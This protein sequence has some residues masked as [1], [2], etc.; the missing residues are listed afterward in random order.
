M[1]NSITAGFFDAEGR[2]AWHNQGWRLFIGQKESTPLEFLRDYYG[3]GSI[4][5]TS[6]GYSHWNVW[7]SKAEAVYGSIA[8]ADVNWDWVLGYWIGD[9]HIAK[10]NGEYKYP[11]LSIDS[12]RSE[13]LEKVQ[14][15]VGGSVY[16]L[17]GRTDGSYSRWTATGSL[18][19][20][21]ARELYS[22]LHTLPISP[23]R[24]LQ[25]RPFMEAIDAFC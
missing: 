12:K 21:L 14:S 7:G 8:S 6:K 23:R 16:P 5:L 3:V 1:N 22:S 13:L 11:F 17:K 10:G 24:A 20:S 9:G 25:L 4:Y 18:G 2:F 15:V 19:R